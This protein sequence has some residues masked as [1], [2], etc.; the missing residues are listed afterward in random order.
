MITNIF[1][2]IECMQISTITTEKDIIELCNKA[3]YYDFYS[4][5]VNSSYVLLAKELLK[6]TNIKICCIVGFPFGAMSTASKVYEAKKAIEDGADEIDM[7]L[8]I[9]FLKSKNYV[10]VLRDIVNV[11]SSIGKIPLKVTLEISELKIEE[12]VSACEIIQD[13]NVNFIKTS[14]GI[15]QK[16]DTFIAVRTIK[17]TLRGSLIRINSFGEVNDLETAI[18]YINSG[19]DRI[20]VS[21]KFRI[22]KKRYQIVEKS[23]KNNEL[24]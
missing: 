6:E 9:G 20:S 21:S 17:K 22:A 13:A 14:N 2:R 5:C 15:T 8:N 24:I 23:K 3:K 7:V 1:K 4:V 11:K 12:I 16:G 19:V 18:K 10:S